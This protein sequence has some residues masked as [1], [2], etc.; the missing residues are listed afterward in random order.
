MQAQQ[1]AQ[2]LNSTNHGCIAEAMECSFNSAWEADIILLAPAFEEQLDAARYIKNVVNQKLVI[3]FDNN[4]NYNSI[5]EGMS[6][7]VQLDLLQQ[8][9]PHSQIAIVR[10]E[11]VTCTAGLQ[12]TTIAHIAVYST[13]KSTV[14]VVAEIFNNPGIASLKKELLPLTNDASNA[15]GT[16]QNVK[17]L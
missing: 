6:P 13:E 2:E 11:A 16:F 14:N 8:I 1:L 15:S 5:G 4:A 10:F 3:S 17:P 9:L 12:A 7:G